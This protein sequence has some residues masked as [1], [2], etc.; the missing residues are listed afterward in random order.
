MIW[1]VFKTF[2]GKFYILKVIQVRVS[3]AELWY[4]NQNSKQLETKHKKITLV[5]K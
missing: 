4:T 5:I 1:S 3:Y 2:I